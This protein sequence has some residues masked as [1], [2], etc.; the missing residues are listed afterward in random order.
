MKSLIRDMR[1]EKKSQ[2]KRVAFKGSIV[3]REK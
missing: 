1:R 3:I 2:N